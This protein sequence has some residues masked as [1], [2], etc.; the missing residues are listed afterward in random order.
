MKRRHTPNLLVAGGALLAAAL[1]GGSASAGKA[2]HVSAT[3]SGSGEALQR[4][5]QHKVSH[6]PGARLLVAYGSRSP[7]SAS[8]PPDFDHPLIDGESVTS[9]QAA[10][11]QLPFASAVPSSLGQPSSVFVHQAYRPQALGLVYRSSPF[12]RFLVIEQLTNQTDAYLRGLVAGCH[13]ETGCEGTWSIVVLNDNGE[14]LFDYR[15]GSQFGH[16]DPRKRHVH[17]RGSGQ[18]IFDQRRAGGCERD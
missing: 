2:Q 11:K 4:Q 7:G 15:S 18:L 8:E 10:G 6:R 13:I 9:V 16:A 14:A 12:G 3:R 5:S 17:D 1:I